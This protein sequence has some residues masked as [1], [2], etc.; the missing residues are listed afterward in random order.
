MAGYLALPL[1][2]YF[3]FILK[4]MENPSTNHKKSDFYFKSVIL[5]SQMESLFY[6]L[7]HSMT[8]PIFD[9][10]ELCLIYANDA[11]PML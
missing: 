4:I 10:S 5:T 9:V 2:I 6:L 3:F 1:H 7:V 11:I 8:I